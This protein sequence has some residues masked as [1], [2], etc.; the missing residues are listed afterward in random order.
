MRAETL[1]AELCNLGVELIPVGDRL[2]FRPASK[3]PPDLLAHLRQCKTEVLGLLAASTDLS[4]YLAMPLDVFAQNGQPLE[5]KVA[6]WPETLFFV[7]AVRDAEALWRDGIGRERVWTA[8]E[9]L[10][11]LEAPGLTPEALRVV[12]VARRE[13]GGEVID[14]RGR[15]DPK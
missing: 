15:T 14:I 2:R 7:P 8:S 1:V 3:V 11:V 9:L 10:F 12:M 13:F 4:R 6:W 5:I